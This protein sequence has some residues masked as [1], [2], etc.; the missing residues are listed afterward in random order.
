MIRDRFYS[1]TLNATSAKQQQQ[2]IHIDI[3][4]ALLSRYKEKKLCAEEV[5]S[6]VRNWRKRTENFNKMK[7]WRG[8]E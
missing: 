3:H 7:I 8:C 1:H 6:D 5:W 4:N 2:K